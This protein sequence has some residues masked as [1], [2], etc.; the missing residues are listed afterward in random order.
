MKRLIP[1]LMLAITVLLSACGGTAN[2]ANVQETTQLTA[3]TTVTNKYVDDDVVNAFVEQYNAIS[4]SPFEDVKGGGKAWGHSY[5]YYCDLLHSAATDKIVITISETNDNWEQ[6]VAGMKDIFRDMMRVIN[7]EMSVDEINEF[8][9]TRTPGHMN[10]VTFGNAICTFVPD[11]ELDSG[12]SR[13]H[14]KVE[15]IG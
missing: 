8:F 1:A 13:G 7:P 6:G 3:L 11:V 9:D 4:D 14:I 10:E 5:G 15:E 2:N 12:H